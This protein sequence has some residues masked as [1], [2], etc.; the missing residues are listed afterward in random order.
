MYG[1]LVTYK[2]LIDPDFCTNVD[3]S[4]VTQICIEG[5]PLQGE[6]CSDLNYDYVMDLVY[7]YDLLCGYTDTEG[8]TKTPAGDVCNA[9]ADVCTEGVPSV[10]SMC[11]ADY[12]RIPWDALSYIADFDLYDICW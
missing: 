9:W 1:E 4:V 11:S 8:N 12:E 7:D 5:N 10:T 2:E 3:Q 6:V